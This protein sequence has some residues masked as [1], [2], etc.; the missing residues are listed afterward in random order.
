MLTLFDSLDFVAKVS[1]QFS[2]LLESALDR[3]A[4]HTRDELRFY[5]MEGA[6]LSLSKLGE[7]YF[8]IPSG[9]YMV[10]TTNNGSTMLVPVSDRGTFDEVYEGRQPSYEIATTKLLNNWNLLGKPSP[11]LE[12][13]EEKD[14]GDEYNRI[15][16]DTVD[17]SSIVSAMKDQNISVSDLADKV[18]VDKSTISRY[19]RKPKEGVQ[20]DPG[21]RTPSLVAAG[22]ISK[23]LRASPTTLF[24]DVFKRQK[25]RKKRKGNRASGVTSVTKNIKGRR[26]E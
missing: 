19:L 14:I 17:R 16:M 15:D 13:E 26:D 20:G 24:P 9:Q 8:S 3:N 11:I 18:G 4:F 2:M 22:E 12:A 23:I 10:Y 25:T 1:N 5:L 6:L 21:G 7:H